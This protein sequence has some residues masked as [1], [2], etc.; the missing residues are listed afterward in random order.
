M[1]VPD[2]LLHYFVKT[3]YWGLT[4]DILFYGQFSINSYPDPDELIYSSL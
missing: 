3:C 4:S 2:F 1:T